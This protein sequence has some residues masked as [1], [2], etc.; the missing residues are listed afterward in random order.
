MIIGISGKMGSGKDEVCNI[1]HE[2][3]S[4]DWKT[5]RFADELKDTV[6]RWIGCTR[7]QL[8]DREF[9]NKELGEEWWYY[10]ISGV[11]KPRFGYKNEADNKICENRYLVRPTP[12][13]ML[14][15]LGTEA[16]RQIIHPNIWVNTLMSQYN[17]ECEDI[18]K[19]NKFDFCKCMICTGKPKWVIPDTRFPN[20]LKAIENK[21]GIVIR[22]E[23]PCRNGT[24]SEHKSETA[25]DGHVFKYLIQNDGTL[26]DLKDSVKMLLQ[27]LQIIT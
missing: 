3:T 6:C 14:Q 18:V 8:E 21:G 17:C 5:K 25:L 9:K 4:S 23:R 19:K 10:D 13:I 26:N 7:E 11:I 12:R 15:R 1:I 27:N 20:E 2:L 24:T 22:I 16:G